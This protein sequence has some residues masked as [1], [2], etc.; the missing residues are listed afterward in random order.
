M[1]GIKYNLRTFKERFLGITKSW[2]CWHALT[3]TR[4]IGAKIS[5]RGQVPKF[6]GAYGD[7]PVRF[8]PRGFIYM[9]FPDIEHV[10]SS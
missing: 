8:P 5:V 1:L 6:L 3:A 9:A 10:F 2:P 7:E 4:N